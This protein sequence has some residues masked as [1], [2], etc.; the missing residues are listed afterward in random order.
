MIGM[1]P[2]AEI[3]IS[4]LKLCNINLKKPRQSHRREQIEVSGERS[5]ALGT[6]EARFLL[7]RT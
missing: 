6:Y 2:A 3:V 1:N 7:P 4:A 5:S